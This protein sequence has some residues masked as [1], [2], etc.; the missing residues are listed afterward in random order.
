MAEELNFYG[1]LLPTLLVLMLAAYVLKV[2]ISRGL[3]FIGFYRFIWH[4]PLF[5]LALYISL[6][7]SLFIYFPRISL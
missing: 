1:V 3:A 6:L 2:V 7:G 5:N 4:P